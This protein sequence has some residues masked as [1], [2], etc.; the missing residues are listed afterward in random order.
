MVA[1]FLALRVSGAGAY[2]DATRLRAWVAGADP[3]GGPL[4]VLVF[5]G[6]VVLQIPGLVFVTASPLL[7]PPL[8]GFGLCILAANLA[9]SANFA[10]VRKL[11]GTVQPPP[12]GSALARAFDRLT[13]TPIRAVALIRLFAFMFPP[14]TAALALSPVR[15]RDHA[16]GSAIGLLPA[17]TAFLWIESELIR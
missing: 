14:I 16:V 8:E 7:F 6:G 4:F 17:V 15:A 3:L 2:L 13:T 12:A 10:V 1:V 9:V 11:G 5:V